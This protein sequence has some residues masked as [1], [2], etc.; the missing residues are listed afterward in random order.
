MVKVFEIVLNDP[1]SPRGFVSGSKLTGKA[2]VKIDEG[3]SYRL[4][5]VGL[6]GSGKIKWTEG[7]GEESET[8]RATEDYVN[9]NL[10][11]W[12]ADLEADTLAAGH[13]EFPFAFSI[14]ES[15]PP[16]WEAELG[17]SSTADAW[18]RYVLT[19]RIS[20]R[21]ALKADHTV[22]QRVRISR[23][24]RLTSTATKPVRR[25][26]E[27]SECCLCC[28]S[29]PIV[30]AAELPRS[31][32]MAG[33]RIPLDAEV[34]NGSSR[35]LRAE[36]SLVKLVKLKA[37]GNVKRL[38]TAVVRETS[39]PFRGGSTTNWCPEMEAVPDGHITM[40]TPGG[41]IM[42]AYEVRVHLGLRLGQKLEVS[43][44]VHIGN[45]ATP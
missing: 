13:H 29:G 9:Q 3:K 30:L 35:D 21:G 19:G 31:G 7:H 32:F 6:T 44:P 43:F 2:V 16:S 22:E 1:P 10:T 41:M 42:V 33:E 40:E 24:T 23:V 26:V 34:E 45:E 18:I 37:S 28:V 27:G 14:P 38:S 39:N 15:C 4:I 25:E 8:H 5:E 12:G 17:S 36:A 11:L 20:T